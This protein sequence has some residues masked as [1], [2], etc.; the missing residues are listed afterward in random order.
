MLLFLFYYSSGRTA[1]GTLLVQ[2]L[3]HRSLWAESSNEAGIY[4]DCG[5]PELRGAVL[6]M[7]VSPF[8]TQRDNPLFEWLIGI[9]RASR[10]LALTLI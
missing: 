4:K 7:A 1:P 6:I 10:L 5:V 2:E 3:P 8:A 9:K